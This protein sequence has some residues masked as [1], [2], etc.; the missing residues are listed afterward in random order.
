MGVWQSDANGHSF[1]TSAPQ[2]EHE[3]TDKA[4]DHSL[5]TTAAANSSRDASTDDPLVPLWRL[6]DTD[7]DHVLAS[8][9]DEQPRLI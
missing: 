3:D 1:A 2:V 7:L 6:F 9:E 4:V 8:L 5:S